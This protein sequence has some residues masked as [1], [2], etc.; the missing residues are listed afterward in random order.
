MSRTLYFDCF[1]GASGDMVLGALLDAG[2]PLDEL[3]K[4]LGSLAIEGDWHVHADRVLRAGVSATKFNLHSHEHQGQHEH[5]EHPEHPKHPEHTEHPKHPEHP[6]HPKHP[7]HPEHRSL[8]EIERAIGRSGLS[9][10]GKQKAVELFRRLGEAEAAIHQVP[11]ER[12]HLHEVGALDSIV[13]IVGA[14]FAMEWFGTDD[15]VASPLNV[16]GGTVTCAHGTFPVP[17]P[18]TARI[19][20]GVPTYSTGAV[21]ELVTPTGALFMTSY[22][23]LFGPMPPMRVERIG[24]GAG[25]RDPA[26]FPNVLRVF[27]GERVETAPHVETIVSLECEIDDMNPQIFGALMDRLRAAGALDVFYAP[28]QMKKNRPGT[29]VT[30]LAPPD[31]REAVADL[32]FRET[33]TIGVRW[34]GMMRERLERETIAVTTPLGEVRVKVARRA[35][36]VV[37]AQP[38]FEDCVRIAE[39]RGVPIK[40]VQA[41]ALQ[42]YRSRA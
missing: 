30:V 37:N 17:A 31:R 34:Q 13:D 25:D 22:A 38:E 40:E 32:L 35:G 10:A 6:E 24:Y 28:V 26:G 20:T 29:L 2:L 14:V 39:A 42:A 12:I 15:V 5:R 8:T 11:V 18:A 36:R 1:A 4:A 19:L 3:R 21:G 27:V 23:K 16:G 7:E 9:P 33:T 41:A